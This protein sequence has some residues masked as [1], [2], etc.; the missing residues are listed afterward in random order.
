M[1]PEQN[2]EAPAN[3]EFRTPKILGV[4][5]ELTKHL[6]ATARAKCFVFDEMSIVFA[7]AEHE[8]VTE[9]ADAWRAVLAFTTAL[10]EATGRPAEA[11]ITDPEC[12][13]MSASG[14][15]FVLVVPSPQNHSGEGESHCEPGKSHEVMYVSAGRPG[16]YVLSRVESGN[17]DADWQIE[18]VG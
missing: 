7:G 13:G 11:F 9:E 5:S 1:I 8:S 12:P 10:Q 16:P 15:P 14:G 17:G 2:T 4:V 18:S 3:S 6:P